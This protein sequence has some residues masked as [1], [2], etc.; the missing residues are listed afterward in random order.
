MI[1]D[2]NIEKSIAAATTTQGMVLSVSIANDTELNTIRTHLT[3][4]CFTIMADLFYLSAL[5]LN[6]Q[7]PIAFAASVIY[8]VL[9]KFL[10]Y[11]WK[12]K[13]KFDHAT[14]LHS[15]Q[16]CDQ[17][18]QVKKT[19]QSNIKLIEIELP[20]SLGL[21]V[22]SAHC[23]SEAGERQVHKQRRHTPEREH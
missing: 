13:S 1:T 10:H 15:A 22:S 17:N 4:F 9:G 8:C 11:N 20:S 5:A 2:S 3:L 21:V 18:C 19:G 23:S 12:D 14:V 7:T 16:C 6:Q